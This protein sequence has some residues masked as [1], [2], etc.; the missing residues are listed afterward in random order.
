[1]ASITE[2]GHAKIVASFEEFISAVITFRSAYNPSKPDLKLE[3]LQSK[4]KDSRAAMADVNKALSTYKTAVAARRTAFA[5]LSRY[6]T[7]ILNA[8]KASESTMAIDKS[9]LSLVRK[10][11]GN[12]I[13]A[14]LTEELKR[15]MVAEG[16]EVTEIS[17]S[18]MS[19]DSRLDNFD[20]LI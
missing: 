4:A 2:T 7:R 6:V 3:A 18:Q 15:A 14:K 20:K 5:S 11:Q 13:S 8:L 12:R 9:A 16:K 19:I 10:I 1:M 17:S